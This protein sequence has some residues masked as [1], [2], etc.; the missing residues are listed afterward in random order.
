[1]N[2][3]DLEPRVAVA[4]KTLGRSMVGV[5]GFGVFLRSECAFD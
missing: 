1:V 5:S 4:E 2:Y 3:L